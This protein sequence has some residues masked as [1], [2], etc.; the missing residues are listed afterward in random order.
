[1]NSKSLI[2]LI[3][4]GATLSGCGMRTIDEGERGVKVQLGKMQSNIMQPGFT[5]YN[6][7]TEDIIVYQIR[8]QEEN[9]STAPL[10]KDQQDI[11]I[12][13]SVWYILP[14]NNVGI[15]YSQYKGD[16]Y[17]GLIQ[18]QVEE[19]FRD[20]VSKYKAEEVI[21]NV[22]AVKSQV[23]ASVRDGLKGVINVKDIMIRDINLPKSLA[24]AIEIKQVEEQKALAKQYELDKERKQ[25]EITVTKAKADAE[26]IQLKAM[27]LRTSP[28][29]VKLEW[30]KKW[31]GK[32]PQTMLGNSSVL[33]GMK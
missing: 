14:P 9:G 16:P 33:Y 21:H 17:T 30:V 24:A 26:A 2:T 4:L 11:T 19:A 20:V 8:Q 25:A 27:A 28:E 23:V 22:E 3:A 12:S 15:F 18:P 32:M 1:M 13:Y 5:F 7:F 6:P 29:L 10:T 31:D